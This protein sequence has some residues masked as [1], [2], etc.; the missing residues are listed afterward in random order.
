MTGEVVD[1]L[2]MSGLEEKLEGS[3]EA[4]VKMVLYPILT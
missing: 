2:F 1:G 4:G 3:K